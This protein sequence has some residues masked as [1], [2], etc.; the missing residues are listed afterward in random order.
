MTV[1][2]V[3]FLTPHHS[4]RQLA[5]NIDGDVLW[6]VFL[7]VALCTIARD[8]HIYL[9]DIVLDVLWFVQKPLYKH[10]PLYAVFLVRGDFLLAALPNKPCMF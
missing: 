6:L 7:N 9:K 1:K 2:Q 3:Q 8:L 10:K 5:W 4:A